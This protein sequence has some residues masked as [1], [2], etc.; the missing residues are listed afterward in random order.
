M[1][2][3]LGCGEDDCFL[4]LF[5]FSFSSFLFSHPR[6]FYRSYHLQL[7]GHHVSWRGRRDYGFLITTTTYPFSVYPFL[8]IHPFLSNNACLLCD[9]P[10]VELCFLFPF[11]L[12]PF[13]VSHEK[14]LRTIQPTWALL[15]YL[16]TI[17]FS[18]Y[19][20]SP[21]YLVGI[22]MTWTTL[23]SALFLLWIHCLFCIFVGIELA[24]L[25]VA[26]QRPGI[27]HPDTGGGSLAKVPV[28]FL[29]GWS[30]W[31]CT[32]RWNAVIHH[33]T[34]DRRRQQGNIGN[35]GINTLTIFNQKIPTSTTPC[36]L[37]FPF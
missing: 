13:H 10:L 36:S 26:I 32:V 6:S 28:M 37:Y 17:Y 15:P 18:V 3:L 14:R 4:F 29:Q 21:D 2:L 31:L 16:P 19:T 27:L 35:H 7:E 33:P 22:F 25:G 23:Q 30:H 9:D 20:I 34:Q 12:P 8:W 1:S 11:C 5:F 24:R